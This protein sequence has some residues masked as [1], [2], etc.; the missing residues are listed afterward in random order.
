MTFKRAAISQALSQIGFGHPER[1]DIRPP[2]PMSAARTTTKNPEQQREAY[3]AAIEK[4]AKR[5]AK[6]I[7]S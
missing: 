4:R 1:A 7:K 2:A 3:F 6:R 5:A